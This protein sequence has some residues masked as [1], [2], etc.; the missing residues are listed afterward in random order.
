MWKAYVRKVTI[1]HVRNIGHFYRQA[2]VV[3]VRQHQNND[4]VTKK[5]LRPVV[6]TAGLNSSAQPADVLVERKY[7]MRQ[8]RGSRVYPPLTILTSVV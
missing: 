7:W 6:H 2:A 3:A 8:G 4:D 1:F 5:K